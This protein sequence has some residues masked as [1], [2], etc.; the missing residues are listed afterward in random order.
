MVLDSN[1]T[2]HSRLGGKMVRVLWV[3]TP[4]QT[5]KGNLKKKRK[6]GRGVPMV[7]SE[8][9]KMRG[10]KASSPSIVCNGLES[11][12]GGEEKML[13]IESSPNPDNHLNGSGIGKGVGR[14]ETEGKPIHRTQ[15]NAD[16]IKRTLKGDPTRSQKL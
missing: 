9:T 12:K 7:L 13:P 6:G 2:M 14:R 4:T 15:A 16:T 1:C 5:L 3:V 11:K 8:G 10:N